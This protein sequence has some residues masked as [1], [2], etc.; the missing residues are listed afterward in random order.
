MNERL[1]QPEFEKL[2]NSVIKL[3]RNHLLYD[4]SRIF[5]EVLIQSLIQF[6][7]ILA[8]HH[9][10]KEMN[11]A[12]E[13]G[14]KIEQ[15]SGMYLDNKEFDLDG[16]FVK[17]VEY[18]INQDDLINAHAFNDKLNDKTVA[19]E[20][21]SRMEKI[22]S[23]RSGALAQKAKGAQEL[24]IFADQ[25]SQLKNLSRDQKMAQ[26]NLEHTRTGLKRRYYQD[27]LDR[28]K[29]NNLTEAVNTFIQTAIELAKTKKF[30]LAG[31]TTAVIGIITLNMHDIN[32]TETQI[33]KIDAAVGSSRGIFHET[34]Q[35]RVMDYIIQMMKARNLTAVKEAI[36]LLDVLPL[37]PE[38]R[39]IL[40]KLMKDSSLLE[41][42][43]ETPS[44]EGESLVNSDSGM[45]I[46]INKIEHD[47]TAN[48]RRLINSFESKY[49]TH[50]QDAFADQDYQQASTY[51]MNYTDEF[52]TRKNEKI[53]VTTLIMGFLSLLKIKSAI[54]VYRDFE[55]YI[56]HLKKQNE[57]FTQL[58]EIKVLD[59][60]IQKYE[61]KAETTTL[62]AITDAFQAKLPLYDWEKA[63]ILSLNN[64]VTPKAGEGSKPATLISIAGDQE[65]TDDAALLT[66]QIVALTQQMSSMK[67]EFTEWKS[68]RDL[69]R[70]AYYNEI[71][72]SI[73]NN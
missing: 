2:I 21:N 48:S 18:K 56:F 65:P 64:L 71:L 63:F 51:Y 38:E 13:V 3:Y 34:Y 40:E 59:Y 54:D 62:R 53:A 26:S 4:E 49:W 35:M 36:R 66:Q 20:F 43:Q 29:A 60:F 39:S 52:L 12:I 70:R 37:F 32:L 68:K 46:L 55:K 15:L 30:E 23:Q 7:S 45:N 57:K 25:L 16:I 17:I 6:G 72:E 69:G 58:A 31:V 27:G 19:N 5:A 8:S 24:K 14:R 11:D 33:K 41:K 28:I 73:K 47:P 50:C 1:P 9:D 10:G 61:D 67:N 42:S 22:E 44:E